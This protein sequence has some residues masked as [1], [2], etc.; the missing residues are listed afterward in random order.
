MSCYPQRNRWHQRFTLK[1]KGRY[2]GD[3]FATAAPEVITRQYVIFV[4]TA[5]TESYDNDNPRS[6]KDDKV[7]IMTDIFLVS[8]GLKFATNFDIQCFIT[9]PRELKG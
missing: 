7:G 5:C 2:I 8:S 4:A 9:L 6:T 3:P 1:P